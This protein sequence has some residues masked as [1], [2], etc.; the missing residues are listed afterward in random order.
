MTFDD[1][2]RSL[3]NGSACLCLATLLACGVSDRKVNKA[4]GENASGAGSRDTGMDSEQ[5]GTGT[6][7]GSAPGGASASGGESSESGAEGG[8]ASDAGEPGVAGAPNPDCVNDTLRCVDM[9]TPSKCVDGSWT[10]Q[11]PCP[12]SKPACSNGLCAVATFSGGIVTVS[13]GVLSTSTAR[14]VEHGLEYTQTT[15]GS[16]GTRKVCVTGGIRP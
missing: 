1:F 13:D 14:L 4:T 9:T 3:R 15:C 12:A 7:T 11:D 10:D 2:H 5:A 6:G 8:K 16:V